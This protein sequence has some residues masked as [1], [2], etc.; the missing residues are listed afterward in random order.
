[1][2]R[3]IFLFSVAMAVI[4]V[5]VFAA[6]VGVSATIGEPG[7][8]GHIEIGNVP[9]PPRLIYP[10][11]V[12]IISPAPVGVALQPVYLHVP[13]GHAKHWDKHCHKYNACGRPVYFVEESWFNDVY[14]PHYQQEH[15]RDKNHDK[16]KKGHGKGRE[17]H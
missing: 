3:F 17:D 16:G 12:I 8:Y 11:P 13:P 2:K 5:P 7:F 4:T 6:D 1:M 10:E 14:V 9:Q 15:G